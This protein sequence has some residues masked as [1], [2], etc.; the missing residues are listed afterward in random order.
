MGDSLEHIDLNA[1]AELRDVME[2]EFAML[3]E[4][5]LN[6]SVNRIAHIREALHAQQADQFGRACHSFKGSCINIGVPRLADL[7]KQGELMGYEGRLADA[8]QLV[9]AIEAEFALVKVL[10]PQHTA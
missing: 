6:D 7:C 1:L 8:P 5:F 3:I 9:E 2:D 10:L 4:T